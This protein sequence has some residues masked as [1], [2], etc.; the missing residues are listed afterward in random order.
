MA[1]LYPIPKKKKKERDREA[2]AKSEV[3]SELKN[4]SREIKELRLEIKNLRLEKS[5]KVTQ[6]ALPSLEP[7]T[8]SYSFTQ[9]EKEIYPK[10]YK[11]RTPPR[12]KS[13]LGKFLLDHID[14]IFF[15]AMGFWFGSFLAYLNGRSALEHLGI[16]GLFALLGF[17]VPYLLGKAAEQAEEE[18]RKRRE[19]AYRK[20][21]EKY[22]KKNG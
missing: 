10:I 20:V 4:L 18:D 14:E 9:P 3:Y 1:Y 19:E 7:K 5:Q 11:I 21:K 8:F 17:S 12:E 16:G 15:A 13:G 2:Y 22:R 6:P